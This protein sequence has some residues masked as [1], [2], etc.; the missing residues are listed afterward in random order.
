MHVLNEELIKKKL[1]H[2]QTVD[3]SSLMWNIAKSH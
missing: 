2:C 1:H 3:E